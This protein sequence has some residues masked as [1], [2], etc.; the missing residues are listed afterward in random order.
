MSGAGGAAGA[1]KDPENRLLWRMAPRRLEAEAIRDAILAAGGQLDRTAGG[2]LLTRALGFPGKEFPVNFEQPRRSVY[3]PVIRGGVYPLLKGFDF[4]DPSVVVGKR[5]NTTVAPQALLMM[6]SQ[7]VTEQSQRFAELLLS[8]EGESDRTRVETAYLRA[9]SRTPSGAEVAR[10]LRF[11]EEYTAAS[12]GARER[13]SGEAPGSY[14]PGAEAWTSF[15][16]AL[17]A[18]TEFRYVQ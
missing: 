2:T 8:R 16:Q 4:A 9:L 15:C 11:L 6:N 13:G 1:A 14:T 10:A 5:D 3:L 7:F 12:E 17:F 18:S